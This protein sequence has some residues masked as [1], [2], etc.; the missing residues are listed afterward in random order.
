MTTALNP[1]DEGTAKRFWIRS[2]KES[3]LSLYTPFVVSLASG[4]LELDTFRHYIAQDVHF[5]KCFAQAYELAKEC[6]DDD[7][8]KASIS[9]LRQSVLEE[10]EMHGSFCQEWGFDVSKET[11][12]NSAT[13]KYT[14]FLFATAS[15]KIDGINCSSNLTP[16]FEKAKIA[17]FTISAMVPCMKL[18]AFLGK[19]LQFL[20]D[21]NNNRHPYKKWI[22]NYSSEAFQAA[23]RQIE[24]LLD[25]LSVD[26]TVEDL[27]V[28]QKLYNQAMKLEMEFFLSQPLNQ[29]TVVPL[30]EWHNRNC[31]ETKEYGVTIF[32]DFDLTCTVIDSCAILGEIAMAASPKSDRIHQESEYELRNTWER[33][34]REYLEEYE[35]CKESMLVNQ[36]VD[37][38]FTVFVI[39]TFILFVFEVEDFNYEGLK[40]ALEQLSDFEKRANMKILKMLVNVFFSKIIAWISFNYEGLKVALEQLSD[41]EKRANMKVIES[42]ILKGLNLE[43]IKN[44]GERLLLQDNCMDFFHHITN[45]E[46]LNVNVHVLSFCWCDDLIKSAFKSK[47]IHNF[48]LHANKFIYEGQ[49]STGEIMKTVESPIDKLQAFTGILKECDK[50][51]TRLVTCLLCLLEADIGIV[52]GSN[53]SIRKVGGHF[54]VSFVPLFHGV[55]MKQREGFEGGFIGWKGLSGVVYTVSS[56]V[57]IHSF[58][59]GS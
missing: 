51:K 3:V 37:Y 8:A 46:N 15:G 34:S 20:V 47:G 9:E 27:N 1:N 36:K 48:Q 29:P 26:L 54:G 43:D 45:N 30:L 59:V 5:L 16:H 11:I 2:N 44:A 14:D 18:Y 31:K 24:E 4:N 58:I 12:P 56:W 23:A 40:V 17:A 21:V 42:K 7:D 25:K 22:D 28:M 10:L 33:L 19:E 13:L 39:V 41:F 55:V 53:L 49:I 35:Q 38:C 57:E 6:A 32:S 52:I 50:K